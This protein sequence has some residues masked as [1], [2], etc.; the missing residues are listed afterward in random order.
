MHICPMKDDIVKICHLSDFHLP[1]PKEV[2]I[3]RLLGKRLLGWANLTFKRSGTHKLKAF[4]AL[5]EHL[6]A[7][8]FDMVVVSGDLVNLA[9]SFEYSQVTE[10]FYK[11]GLVP[12]TTI[13][14]PGNHDRY[15]PGAQSSGIFERAMKQW[16]PNGFSSRTGYPI[17]RSVGPVTI[18]AM[19]T[20]VWRGPLRAAGL[21]K[22]SSLKRLAK[23]VSRDDD[24]HL[25]VVTH[26]PPFRLEGSWNRH[27]RNGLSGYKKLVDLL[28]HRKCTL[29]HGHLHKLSRRQMGLMDVIGVPSASNVTGYLKSQLSYHV[30]TFDKSGLINAE[31]VVHWPDAVDKEHRFERRIIPGEILNV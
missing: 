2:P 9:L 14:L 8:D 29:L 7:Q 26:H 12:E 6:A 27:Y 5:L 17:V 15:T 13:V 23:V 19:D 25:V 31:A 11:Y 18:A 22:T 3:S 1:L 20:A 4:E 30:Y 21:V 28:C 16:L 24:R 10:L